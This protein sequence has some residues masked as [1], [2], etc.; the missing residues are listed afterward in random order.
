V[1]KMSDCDLILGSYFYTFERERL[2][3]LLTR[4][5]HGR[6]PLL[7]ILKKAYSGHFSS[8]SFFTQ[9]DLSFCGLVPDVSRG[10]AC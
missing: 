5:V 7:H 9:E 6:C 8:S 10:P 1:T 3:L 4:A 2:A